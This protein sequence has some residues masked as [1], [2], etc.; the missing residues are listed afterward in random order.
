MSTQDIYPHTIGFLLYL[1]LAAFLLIVA[2][3]VFRRI[4]RRDY[5]N[6]GRLTWF[7]SL[8]SWW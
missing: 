2:Y 5:L 3:I 6:K 8:L 4:G 7:S 1:L